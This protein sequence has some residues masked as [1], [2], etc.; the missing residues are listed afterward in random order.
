MTFL[1]AILPSSR[2]RD[3]ESPQPGA[4]VVHSQRAAAS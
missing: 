4:A 3:L 1:A 2:W